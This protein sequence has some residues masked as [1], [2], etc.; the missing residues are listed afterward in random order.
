MLDRFKHRSIDKRSIRYL[1]LLALL[2]L[3]LPEAHGQFQSH[4]LATLKN[5]QLIELKGDWDFFPGTWIEAGDER[6]APQKMAVDRVWNME[7]AEGMQAGHGLAT[8]RLLLTD[9]QPRLD[10][11]SLAI[12]SASAAMTLM[13]YP[14][15]R[16]TE[17]RSASAGRLGRNAEEEIPQLRRASLRFFPEAGEA[18]WMVLVQVSN[19]H[20]G[21]GGLWT[22]PLLGTGDSAEAQMVKDRELLIFCL[23]MI[24]VIG[25]YNCMLF[26]RRSSD[27]STLILAI[28][29]FVVTL[30]AVC[31]DNLISWYFPALDTRIY[32]LKYLIEYTTMVL[33]PLCCLVFIHLNF[34]TTSFAGIYRIVVNLALLAIL[35]IFILDTSHYSSILVLVQLVTMAEIILGLAMVVH[36]VRKKRQGSMLVAMACFSLASCVIYDILITFNILSQPYITS[37]GMSIFVFIQSQV[38]AQRFAKAFHMAEHLSV[39]LKDEVERQT[40][41]LRS[42]MENIPQGVFI[43]LADQSIQGNYSKELEQLLDQ[44]DLAGLPALPL[45]FKDAALTDDERSILK[46]ILLSSLGEPSYVWDMNRPNLIH[47]FMRQGKDGSAQILTVDWHPIVNREELVDRVLVTLRNVTELRGLQ[48]SLRKDQEAFALLLEIVQVSPERFRDFM[49]QSQEILRQAEQDAKEEDLRLA[50]RKLLMRL[51]TW[52]GLA[53]SLQFKNLAARIHD[54]E[55]VLGRGP[56]DDVALWSQELHELSDKLHAYEEVSKERLGR[57]NAEASASTI[58]PAAQQ[59]LEAWHRYHDKA[60]AVQRAALDQ[61]LDAFIRSL[62]QLSCAQLLN[63]LESELQQLAQELKKPKPRLLREG[64][65]DQ[66]LPIFLSRRLNYALQHLIRNSMDHGIESPEERQTKGKAEQGCIRVHFAVEQ[67]ALVMDYCDDGRGLDWNRV[68][69]KAKDSGLIDAHASPS[70]HDLAQF[71]FTPGF[72][73]RCEANMISGRGIG[74]DAVRLL[75]E[76]SG[77]TM[78]LII[79]EAGNFSQGFRLRARWNLATWIDQVA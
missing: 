20:Y 68:L 23:G 60:D 18:E 34:P 46:S 43:M 4:S 29:C 50:Q 9:L 28:F 58:T 49:Q 17:I 12:R 36:A 57:I 11:Y 52:K 78:E 30:R 65:L 21:R 70:P 73:T 61:A 37:V 51:H 42:I 71:I 6:A 38:V 22:A 8:Y 15:N 5:G 27:K 7:A 66:T 39:K 53:R 1:M 16:P 44:E 62:P 2:C 14:K 13:I 77:G 79:E 10:G 74:M 63:A 24:L 59:L 48:A 55:Q 67:G 54:A 56:V 69:R 76:E 33:G 45:L 41:E 64:A 3:M 19:F 25:F 72:S 40:L 31:S 75:V 35:T 26:T 32:R 47:E